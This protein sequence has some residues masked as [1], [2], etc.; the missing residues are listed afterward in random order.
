VGFGLGAIAAFIAAATKGGDTPEPETQEQRLRKKSFQEWRNR[1]EGW[2]FDK[3]N[4]LNKAQPN[5]PRRKPARRQ[6][7]EELRKQEPEGKRNVLLTLYDCN[8][9]QRY[10]YPVIDL[11]S[12]DLSGSNLKGVNLYGASLK[13]AN[14]THADLSDAQFGRIPEN[15]STIEQLTQGIKWLMTGSTKTFDSC[16][17][18]GVKLESAV[19]RDAVLIGCELTGADFEGTDLCNADLRGADLREARNLTQE[20]ANKAYGSYQQEEMPDTQ[21]PDGFTVPKPWRNPIRKQKRQR[22]GSYF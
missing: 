4:P 9:I 7:L 15:T 18:R 2:P 20:Q 19:L 14:L 16:N 11:E 1:I 22:D 10:P 21:L 13:K 12:A 17:L 5:D 3:D 8:L 6:T